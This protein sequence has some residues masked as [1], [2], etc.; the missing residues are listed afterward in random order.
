MQFCLED[1]NIF[2]CFLILAR[3]KSQDPGK[4]F[5]LGFIAEIIS[6]KMH[7]SKKYGHVLQ[8]MKNKSLAVEDKKLTRVCTKRGCRQ[9]RH[10][11]QL[12]KI[13]CELWYMQTEGKAL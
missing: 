10:H 11:T 2:Q 6:R 8:K 7:L 9:K 3:S 12:L 13:L 5:L 1:T 4:I